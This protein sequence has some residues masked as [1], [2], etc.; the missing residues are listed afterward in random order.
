MALDNHYV[1]FG[2]NQLLVDFAEIIHL[3]GGR[4]SKIVCNV[5]EPIIEGRKRLTERLPVVARAQAGD[6]PEVI[7]L[8][9]F[10]PQEG[11]NYI[12]GVPGR[13]MEP[14]V[15]QLT[16]AFGLEFCKLIHPKAMVSASAT[17]SPGCII[18][19][20]AIIASG[21]QLDEH[22]FINRGA[23]IG[24]DT[25]IQSHG[26]VQPNANLA[27]YIKMGRGAVV[28]LGAAVIEDRVIGDRSIVAAGSVVI[29]DVPPETMVAGVPAV[30]KKS[31]V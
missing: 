23:T 10:E 1:M 31:L 29:R 24:H 15:Q 11:E 9:D 20:G 5:K 28:G 26:V 18:N 12:L 25:H 4:L 19:T 8:D 2:Y 21:V 7:W 3:N 6:A 16:D 22:V 27:G 30:S 14:L 13:K 17:I